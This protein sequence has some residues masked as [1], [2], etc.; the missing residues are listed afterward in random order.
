MV[1]AERVDITPPLTIPYLGYRRVGRH[2]YFQ[3]IHDPLYAKAVVIDDGEQRIALLTA[4]SIGWARSIMGE[5]RDFIEEVRQRAEQLCGIAPDHIM[6]SATHAHSTPETVGI[7]RLLD[8]PVARAWLETLADQ[9]ASAIALADHNRVAVCL[10]QAVGRAEGIGW[11]RRILGKD[12]RLYNLRSWADRPPDEEI[13]DWGANDP[14]VTV[15]C[16]EEMGTPKTVLI[17][18]ACHPVTV[19]VQPLVSADFPGAATAHVERVGI[20]CQHCIYLQ[21]AAGSINP[22]RGTT[23]FSDVARY[24]QILAGEV[25][26]LLG[27]MSAPD[28]PVATNKVD[29]ALQKVMVPSRELPDSDALAQERSRWEEAI[30]CAGTEQKRQQAKERALLVAEQIERVKK[31]DAPRE[32]E[33]QVLRVGDAAL[34]GIPGEPFCEMGLEVKSWT[35]APTTLA[36]GYANDYLGYIAPPAAWEQGGYEVSLGMWSIVGPEAFGK[37]LGTGRLLVKTLF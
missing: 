14:E 20:G 33:V 25:T 4:D 2:Q 18:F 15:L 8:H 31:G 27:I 37:I 28:Y 6:V 16:F 21:G 3:G 10:K 9:L 17:H 30:R 19:Q 24:G 34:V 13:A 36:I 22:A 26:K 12:G 1:G 32:A 23:D 7:R 35:E 5:G 11:S 29:A